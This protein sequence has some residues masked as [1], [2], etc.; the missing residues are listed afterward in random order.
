MTEEQNV[1]NYWSQLFLSVYVCSS[2]RLKTLKPK[3]IFA[4]F[5]PSLLSSPEVT[6][7]QMTRGSVPRLS[8][9]MSRGGK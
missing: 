8:K 3:E 5:P 2:Y 9:H 7:V 4:V 1:H 6:E